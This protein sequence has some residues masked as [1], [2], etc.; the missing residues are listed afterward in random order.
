MKNLLLCCG[1]VFCSQAFA[2]RPNVLLL[3]SDDQRPDTIAA[4]GNDL[5]ETPNLDRFV[6]SG[7]VFTRATC[8]NPIC[9]PSRAEILTGSSGFRCGVMDFG[10]PI[11]AAIP[12]MSRWFSAA[13]YATSYVGKW[14]NDGK[15]VDR[16]YHF[17]RGLYRGGGGKFAKPQV[18]FAGRPVT[19]YRGWIFQDDQGNLFPEKGVGL[20]PEISRHFADAAIETIQSSGD[21]P[22]F[23]HVNFTSPHDPLML[24]PGWETKYDPDKMKLPANFLSEHPFDH[25]N[26]D[27]RDEKL[28][29]WPRTPQETRREIAAYYAVISYMD[30]QIGRIM[31][32][33]NESGK[34]DNTVVVFSSDH[35]LSVGSHGLRGKQSMYEHTIGV[36]LLM[37]GPGIPGARRFDAQ[38]YL[39]DLF[40][41]LCD[42]VGIDG[43]G[44]QIDGVS[45]K[46]VLDGRT[47]RIHEFIV[48]YFRNF[49][50]MI[51]T[52]D[53][54]YIEYP[55][56]N[57][58]QLFHLKQDPD[59][60]TNLIAVE[61]HS[62][63]RE[64][65]RTQMTDWFRNQGDSVYARIDA[66]K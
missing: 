41:T 45:L 1:F 49:Q 20:T 22:F 33:L 10:K 3:I 46:P 40:P 17:T 12:T 5:I 29:L 35:G 6:R 48:G 57:R 58:E 21:T 51:R 9:T 27:G 2:E 65:L 37:Q 50:R 66:E 23:L 36:P 8:S 14:H 59:E 19:G 16:G 38:C 55:A 11:D 13:G 32:A 42:L 26:F 62:A 15:P 53:W 30:E 28:F 52:D 54:K 61:A 63:V 47:E 60:Q 44:E 31:A 25:G 7:S 18:D 39:R 56:V 4:L 34:A 43:P 64:R 24:P